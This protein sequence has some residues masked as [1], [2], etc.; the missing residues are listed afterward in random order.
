MMI[1]NVTLYDDREQQPYEEKLTASPVNSESLRLY[2]TWYDCSHRPAL[3]LADLLSILAASHPHLYQ[4][5]VP[6]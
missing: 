5:N 6:C 2:W 3:W 4:S 1:R